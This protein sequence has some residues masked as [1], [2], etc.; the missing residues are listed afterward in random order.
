MATMVER[1]SPHWE[2]DSVIINSSGDGDA[3][4]MTSACLSIGGAYRKS[5]EHPLKPVSIKDESVKVSIV[6]VTDVCMR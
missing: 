6:M 4:W 2:R 5:M 3:D 1:P